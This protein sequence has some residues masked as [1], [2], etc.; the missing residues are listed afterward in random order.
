MPRLA[1]VASVRAPNALVTTV[2]QLATQAGV[3]MLRAGGSAADAAVAANAV[4]AVTAQHSCG[5]GGDLFAVVGRDHDEP[6]VLNASGRAGS[7][8]DA[9]RLRAEGATRMPVR[10]DIRAVPVPGCVDGWLALHE[11]F[12]KLPRAAVL[13]PARAY[14][15]LG[16][17][18][19]PLLA[20]ALATLTIDCREAFV[21]DGPLRPGVR[22]R[23]PGV[24][25]ALEAIIRDGRDGFYRGEFGEELLRMGKGE[26]VADDLARAH[27]D[28]VPPLHVHA[29]GHDV[30]PAP[31]NSQGY[32]TLASAGIADGLALPH[33]PDD[34]QWAH[35]LVEAAKQ[36]G[37]DRPQVLQEH[38]DG[39][40]LIAPQRLE[41][42]RKA[43]DPER[44]A[45]L[46]APASPSGTMHLN[47]A[48][49]DGLVVSLTQ[50]NAA[51]FGAHLVVPSVGIFLQ[52]RGIGF[53]LAPGH[54]AEYGPG[55]R[56]PH[57]LAVRYG[58][59]TMG[60]D[61]Q[62][63][64][65]LQLLARLLVAGEEPADAVAAARWILAAP[66]G[67]T[68]ATWEQPH[69]VRVRVERHAPTA[70][71]EGLRE[72]GHDV[73]EIDAF[74]YVAGHAHV[75]AIEDDHFAGASDPRALSA[76]AAGY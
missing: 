65:L 33:D 68:F 31:P 20:G 76:A 46:P 73:E 9:E 55:R 15:E 30:W 71:I 6:I 62:P 28:W 59:G 5:M 47:A 74:A 57:T 3:A 10:G 58:L 24:A 38:A 48:D 4:L 53:S 37:W 23:R 19:S 35:L 21:L 25:R 51:G 75:L 66:S 52:N 40:A 56:P 34:P 16:F 43:I 50:S 14:A 63:Q 44:A 39:E 26:Y 1:P 17:P 22:L 13:E 11:R 45:T 70:W 2:D 67:D 61:S 27:A 54:P 64:V 32:L 7:G 36:A 69:G 12:G 8:A 72:R 18:A 60:A 42:R 29:W 41:A 49:R